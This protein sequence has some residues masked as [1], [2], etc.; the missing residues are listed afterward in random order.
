[1][2]ENLRCEIESSNMELVNEVRKN[3]L[4]DESIFDLHGTSINL[5]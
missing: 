1:M 5:F 2:E 4:C 3:M